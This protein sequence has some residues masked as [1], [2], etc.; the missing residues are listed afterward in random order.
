MKSQQEIRLDLLEGAY[1]LGGHFS[2]PEQ[3]TLLNYEA[4]GGRPHRVAVYYRPD[5]GLFRYDGDRFH[6]HYTLLPAAIQ[7][8]RLANRI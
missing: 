1:R 8:L 3:A 4:S 5:Q 6:G 2:W 7:E